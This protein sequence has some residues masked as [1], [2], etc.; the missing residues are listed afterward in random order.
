MIRGV[1]LHDVFTK[2]TKKYGKVYGYYFLKLPCVVVSDPD[3]LKAVF[4][5]DFEKFHDR[6]VRRHNWIFYLFVSSFDFL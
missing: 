5:K 3:I 4:V 6:P 1:P 2:M